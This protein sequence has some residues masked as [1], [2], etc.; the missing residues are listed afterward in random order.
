MGHPA[1][2][3]SKPRLSQSVL[4]LTRLEFSS[5]RPAALDCEVGLL[6][7]PNPGTVVANFERPRSCPIP[8]STFA[9]GLVRPFVRPPPAKE[10]SNTLW[11]LA[12]V[13]PVG[14]G[15]SSRCA[16]ERSAG[17]A[18]ER[19]GG[20]LCLTELEVRRIPRA[21]VDAAEPNDDGPAT[22]SCGRAGEHPS[23]VALHTRT[24]MACTR[25]ADSL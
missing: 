13:V 2:N 19:P 5:G 17:G 12:R 15:G 25:G 21:R 7:V 8:R 23:A 11:G 22:D 4:F 3:T 9:G 18:W 10:L 14:A 20:D 16:E 24:C 1:G 6:F